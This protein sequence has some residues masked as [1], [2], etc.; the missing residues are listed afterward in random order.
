[1]CLLQ[2]MSK[3]ASKPEAVRVPFANPSRCAWPGPI[4]TDLYHPDHD[5]LEADTCA[6]SPKP[7]KMPGA[8][9]AD[10]GGD[11]QYPISLRMAGPNHD[12]PVPPGS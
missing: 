4:T 9:N 10:P 5:K 1:M 12:R 7:V 3:S 8:S 2:F 11:P 6:G